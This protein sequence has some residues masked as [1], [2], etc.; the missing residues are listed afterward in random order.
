MVQ[1]AGIIV[2]DWSK[3]LPSVL[4]VRAYANWDFPKGKV[5]TG[6]SLEQAAARELAEETSLVVGKDVQMT[7]VSAPSVTYGSGKREKTATYFIAD[8]VSSATPFLPVSE[9]L[10]KPE[11]D[12]YRW[13]EIDDL[14]SL[15]PSRLS[16]VVSYLSDWIERPG[17]Y[18]F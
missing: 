18:Y 17:K 2:V 10:G 14:Q 4:C 3:R 16:N 5:E 12:E 11:N 6:E 8:R 15:M 9:E 13:V 1:S 7:G